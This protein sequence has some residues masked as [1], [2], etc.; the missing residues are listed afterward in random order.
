[1]HHQLSR[2]EKLVMKTLGLIFSLI[3]LI[4]TWGCEQESSITSPANQLETSGKISDPQSTMPLLILQGQLCESST[5][6]ASKLDVDGFVRY[7]LRI[8]EDMRSVR[9]AIDRKHP[10]RSPTCGWVNVECKLTMEAKL[11][12]AGDYSPV[13]KVSGNSVDTVWVE[14]GTPLEKSYILLG[15]G[16]AHSLHI[17]FNLSMDDVE[18]SSMWLEQSDATPSVVQ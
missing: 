14:V 4:F 8:L 10:L 3:T 13:W 9:T 16:N 2:K 5:D 12:G 1:M 7:E 15:D 17:E 11:R 6:C 18:I